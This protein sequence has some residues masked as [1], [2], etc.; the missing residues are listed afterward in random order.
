M[1]WLVSRLGLVVLNVGNTTTFRRVG[2]NETIIDVSFASEGLSTS[3]NNWHVMEDF[4][5]SDH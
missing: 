5:T 1:Y 4:T 3:V 2:Y